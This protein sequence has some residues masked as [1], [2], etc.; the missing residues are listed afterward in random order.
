M[1][2]RLEDMFREAIDIAYN[3][4]E[5]EKGI[6]K[7]VDFLLEKGIFAHPVNI[8]DKV[9]YRISEKDFIPVEI[10]E[11]RRDKYTTSYWGKNRTQKANSSI[12]LTERNFGKDVFF[13]K[14]EAKKAIKASLSETIK[15]AEA[16]SN[17]SKPV[18]KKNI[19]LEKEK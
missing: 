8:G 14:E 12:Y 1:R 10:I 7:A 17:Q 19:D 16:K 11:I 6:K 2:E 18:I 15:N 5:P 9:Y 4:F 13:S 3:E